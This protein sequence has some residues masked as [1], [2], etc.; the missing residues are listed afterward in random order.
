MAKKKSEKIDIEKLRKMNSPLVS[1]WEA[2]AV[3]GTFRDRA[4]AFQADIDSALN[5]EHDENSFMGKAIKELQ[6]SIDESGNAN[7]IQ[8]HLNQAKQQD[9]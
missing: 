5:E 1:V 6:H 2:F 3:G 7:L 8:D 4:A 9:E